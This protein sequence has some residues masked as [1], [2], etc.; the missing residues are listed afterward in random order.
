MR[1]P[2][3]F[4]LVGGIF[5]LTVL[6]YV[7]RIC[8]SAAKEPIAEDLAL[9]DTQLGWIFS[10][11]SLGYALCQTPAGW[12]SDRFGPRRILT[13]VVIFWSMFTGLTGLARHFVSLFLARLLFGAGEAGAFP[14]IARAT[15]SWI[16]MRER[17]LVQGIGFSGSRLG[18]AFAL[19]VITLMIAQV[20]WRISF[21]IL[22]VT[23]LVW[24]LLWYLLF[25]DDPS[26]VDRLD[27]D[28]RAMILEQRQ[29]G[30]SGSGGQKPNELNLG[31][32][33]RSPNMWLLSA[34]Y[35]CSNFTFFFCLTWL[36][37]KLRTDHPDLDPAVISI[38]AAIPLICGALGNWSSGLLIDRLY[39]S[40]R[41][42]AS[43][44]ITAIAGFMLA[45][46][47]AFGYTLADG[48]VA[49]TAWLSLAIFGADMTLAPSWSTSIDIGRQHAG[50]VSGTMNMAGNIG[51]FL[52]SL[53]FPYLAE[54]AEQSGDSSGANNI[55]FYLAAGLNLLAVFVWLNIDPKRPLVDSKPSTEVDL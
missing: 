39:A 7:D 47:G 50:V 54:W 26:E 40:G 52:T 33:V 10:A 9:S 38:Y 27:P 13:A 42:V 11:F 19:P 35:F 23:G 45:T 5:L 21:G 37:P 22:M 2:G 4:I 18:A 29:D 55:Y 48:I 16:P 6:L 34:Q 15:F 43:R 51:A 46:V 25:R 3:R 30:P 20:G 31:S 49:E 32:L 41:W 44:R 17:G 12:L 14:G 53:A 8:I 1:V 24:A 28:E 36:L